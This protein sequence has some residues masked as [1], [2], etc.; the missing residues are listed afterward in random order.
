[1]AYGRA[2]RSA[3]RKGCYAGCCGIGWR[4]RL[5]A[6]LVWVAGGSPANSSAVPT[7]LHK[8]QESASGAVG[9]ARFTAAERRRCCTRGAAAACRG[10]SSDLDPAPLA[11]RVAEPAGLSGLGPGV[12]VQRFAPACMAAI[13]VR[14]VPESTVTTPKVHAA[15]AA[16]SMQVHVPHPPQTQ[17]DAP[18][19][20]ET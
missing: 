16:T 14:D 12:P 4:V 3:A 2:N 18:P 15:R 17:A 9:A 8:Q 20:R 10:Y 5:L 11:C 6:C 1:M 7:V 19:P 13:H